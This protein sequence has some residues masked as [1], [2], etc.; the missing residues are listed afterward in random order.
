[1]SRVSTFYWLVQTEPET[2]EE[3]TEEET[4]EETTEE[5]TTEEETTEEVTTEEETTE[6]ETTQTEET[7]ETEE[8]TPVVGSTG[9][10]I[11][12]ILLGAAALCVAVMIT[13]KK[14]TG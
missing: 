12:M 5:Q 7:E 4:E 13:R 1:M 9:F 2:E 3:T 8:D 11:W 14:I 6:E 10:M